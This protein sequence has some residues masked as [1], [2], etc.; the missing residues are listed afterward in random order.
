MKTVC[1]DNNGKILYEFSGVDHYN[2]ELH[3]MADLRVSCY[4]VLDADGNCVYIR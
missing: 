4:K 3:L 2:A 1:Y